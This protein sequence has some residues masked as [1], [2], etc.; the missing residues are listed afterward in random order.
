MAAP[1]TAHY[2]LA[3]VCHAGRDRAGALTELRAC[4][5][6]RPDHAGARELLARLG[7]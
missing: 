7:P 6:L 4:L 2:H 5:A 3:L 1:A